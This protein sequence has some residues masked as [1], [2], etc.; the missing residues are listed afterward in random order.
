MPKLP[1]LGHVISAS[2]LH[3]N[4]DHVLSIQ[5]APIPHDAQSLNLFG[6]LVLFDP[7][8]PTT[9]TMDASN[10]GTG[11]YKVSWHY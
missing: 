3:P 1:F 6:I 8:L 5:Q 11:A 10:Y 9:V 2:G 7:S 4:P